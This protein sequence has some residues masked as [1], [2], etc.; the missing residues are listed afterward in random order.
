MYES[1]KYQ[2]IV[3]NPKDSFS[4]L[5]GTYCASL[6]ACSTDKN[7]NANWSK[8]AGKSTGLNDRFTFVL[9]PEV[10]KPLTPYCHVSTQEGSIKTRQLIDKAI[11]KGVYRIVDSS[12]LSKFTAENEDAN[13][14]E[15]RAEK[16]A[17]GLAVDMGLDEID[18]ET[19][20]RAL[21]LVAYEQSVK[22]YLKTYEASTREGAIQLEVMY[23]LRKS[24]GRMS[25]RDLYRV[26]HPE[27][28]G[29]SLW[30]TSYSGLIKS[31][32]CAEQ[33]GGVKGAPKELILL[34]M[35]EEDD[36]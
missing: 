30:A 17:L 9:P 33:G 27:R 36:D 29:T 14:A 4:F 23:Q 13:R 2:N 15:I 8:L 31:G 20:E 5:P 18:E 25:L 7:F 1:G 22:A 26:I 32:W 10:L 3:K 21:A 24:G 19:I 12:P 35:P 11:Q 16:Y 34:R 28:L 6:I